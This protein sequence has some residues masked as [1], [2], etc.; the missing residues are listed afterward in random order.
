MNKLNIQPFFD[1]NTQTVTYV[2]TDKATCS[3]AVIDPVLD[4]DPTSG[5]LSSLT[6]NK[7]AIMSTTLAG[8]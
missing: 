2:V 4:F 7:D 1:E 3:T 8:P 5:K 6:F